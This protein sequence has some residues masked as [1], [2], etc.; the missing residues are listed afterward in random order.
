MH[1]ITFQQ[2]L[3][4]GIA[5]L[6]DSNESFAVW[7]TILPSILW[8]IFTVVTIIVI[9]KEIRG[10]LVAIS[11]RLGSGAEFILGPLKL[12][13]PP[14]GL[15]SKQATPVTSEGIKGVEP[16]LEVN[17]MMLE[18]KYPDIIVDGIYIVHSSAILKKYDAPGTG[19]WQVKLCVEA[20]EDDS[21]L[22]EIERVTYRLHDTFI[23]KVI[24]TEARREKFE[25][26]INLYGEI[27]VIA[28][29]ERKNKPSVW[30]TRY[31]DLPGRPEN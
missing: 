12:G 19:L 27:N 28:Y 5:F 10:L 25:L 15:G 8:F 11:L 7:A 2:L 16:S 26:W 18:R 6:A 31:I 21:L 17:T 29:V 1:A 9:R 13:T 23:R 22:D 4:Y 20:Y 24:S 30:L 14:S 3:M